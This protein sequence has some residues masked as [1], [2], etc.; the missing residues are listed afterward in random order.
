MPKVTNNTDRSIKVIVAYTIKMYWGVDDQFECDV[1]DWD[2]DKPGGRDGFAKFYPSSD[3]VEWVL[4]PG[5]TRYVECRHTN[6]CMFSADVNAPHV[7]DTRPRP[8]NWIV[9]EIDPDEHIHIK[10][11]PANQHWEI[12]NNEGGGSHHSFSQ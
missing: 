1:S 11:Y 3:A 12:S 7:W 5:E 9:G 2:L 10:Y 6:D 4:S 8:P